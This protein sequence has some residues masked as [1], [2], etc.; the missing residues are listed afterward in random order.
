MTDEITRFLKQ[1]GPSLSSEISDHLVKTLRISGDAARKRVSRLPEGVKRLGF[2]TFPRKARFIYHEQQFGSE[3]YWERLI[4]ALQKTNS[5]YGFAIA[6]LRLRSGI[7]PEAHFK[8]MCG[9]PVRQSKHLSPDTIFER[10]EKAGLLQKIDVPGLGY[11]I[12]LANYEGRYDKLALCVRAR[13]VTESILLTTIRDWVR[14]LGLVSYERVGTRD[15]VN[16][17]MVGTFAWD[18]TAPSYLGPMSRIGRDGVV[19][20]GFLACDVLLE[21]EVDEA[22]I[23]PFV[24]KCLTLRKLRNVGPCLQMFVAERY[25]NDAFLALKRNGII[26]ATPR[27]LFGQ[28]V[29]EALSQVTS[30]LIEAAEYAIDPVKLD[31]LFKRLGKIEGA[32]TQ[33]RGT[34]L[35]FMAAGYFSRLVDNVWT[36]RIF[37]IDG[38]SAEADVVAVAEG[39]SVTFVECKGYSPYATIPDALVKKWLQKSIPIFHKSAL[40]HPDW[41]G[42]EIKF[43]FWATGQLSPE[44]EAMFSKAAATIKRTRYEVR[45]LR[46]D[47]IL[48]NFKSPRDRSLALALRNH[49][50]RPPAEDETVEWPSPAQDEDWSSFIEQ[51][52]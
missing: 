41:R 35:E 4:A 44:A 34:L 33:L 46:V 11:C 48:S 20:P 19:K 38:Q 7:V 2:I 39:V 8:I 40:A 52:Q 47:D 30:V 18:M 16:V 42:L 27:T 26:P 51:T 13:L 6:G 32:A 3:L 37:K 28:E 36:N 5:A 22:G 12:C 43:E 29:S 24:R 45:L 15:G 10:L 31:G 17:P 1:S 14:K 23:A 25:S 9:A 50:M 49:F 21:S